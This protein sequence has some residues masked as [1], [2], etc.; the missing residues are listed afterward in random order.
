MKK[1]CFCI[2]MLLMYVVRILA[3]YN[4]TATSVEILDMTID[5]PNYFVV[6]MT[7]GTSG[8]Y[9]VS[10]DVWPETKSAI[11]S[12][13]NAEGTVKWLYSGLVKNETMYY[14]CM[15]DSK[16]E[17]SIV[18]NGDSTCTLS[19]T[20][21]ASRNGSSYTYIIA[22]FVFP[23]FE[24]DVP[25]VP[26]EN[27]YRFEPTQATQIDFL[28]DVIAVRDHTEDGYMEITLNRVGDETYDWIDLKWLTDTFAM[29]EGKVMVDSVGTY[30]TLTASRGYMGTQ[31]D[32]PCYVALRGDKEVWGQYTPY[33][34]R[35]G[36]LTF[37]INSQGDSVHVVGQL[38]S[39]FGSTIS[40]DV[41]SYNP[42]YEQPDVPHKKEQVC[43]N[44]DTVM[45]T[46]MRE[47]SD[48]LNHSHFYTFN[49]FSQS[50]DFPNVIADVILS[51]PGRLVSGVYGRKQGHISSVA[52]YQNQDD[53]T[54][55]FF[56]GEPYVFDT[57][58][59]TLI[60][61]TDGKWQYDMIITDTI[62]SR[63]TFTMIQDPH[64]IIYP[65][66]VIVPDKDKPYM[67]ESKQVQTLNLV[68]DSMYWDNRT[69]ELDNVLGVQLFTPVESSGLY[70]MAELGMLTKVS[71]VADGTYPIN[72]SDADNTFFASMGKIDNVLIPCYLVQRDAMGNVYQ[73]WYLV[74]GNVNVTHTPTHQFCLNVVATTYFG[75]TVTLQYEGQS[76]GVMEVKK[77]SRPTKTLRDGQILIER[78]GEIYSIMGQSL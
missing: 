78:G 46:Y 52:L 22:P 69:V 63:Y 39:Y 3:A 35:E 11:G 64:L 12:F 5:K 73:V 58:M 7:Q 6:V 14:D 29:P 34:V 18:N 33:Y 49:F 21:Q 70:F 23:Y 57:V 26:D 59:L 65:D 32:D 40:V 53:F 74:S 4:L 75:S 55:A 42:F 1:I 24:Q 37:A 38:K 13:S 54:S 66:T 71:D 19:A 9:K 72:D 17:V 20:V 8:T 62:G 61:L 51:E 45:V 43:L 44:I 48:T 36:D 60:P 56:G 67:T 47:Q 68:C 27:P 16:I 25:P 50:S 28:G 41:T 76:T 10:L 15:E 31:H 77:E 30:N 2:V